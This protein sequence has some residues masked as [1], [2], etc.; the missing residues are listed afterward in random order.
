MGLSAGSD[1]LL[2]VCSKTNYVE[3]EG[4]SREAAI[5]INFGPECYI[6]AFF[7]LNLLI[8]PVVHT[9]RLIDLH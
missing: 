7:I 6:A 4:N 3:G 2:G 8:R 5:K 1:M 9:D